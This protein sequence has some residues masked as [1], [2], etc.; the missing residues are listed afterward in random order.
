ML[1]TIGFETMACLRCLVP[2]TLAQ[3][4]ISSLAACWRC[5]QQFIPHTSPA[6]RAAASRL[7]SGFCPYPHPHSGVSPARQWFRQ[8]NR[9]HARYHRITCSPIWQQYYLWSHL[10][11][12]NETQQHY[13]QGQGCLIVLTNSST[14]LQAQS[15]ILQHTII[16]DASTIPLIIRGS[17]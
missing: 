7:G 4:G 16:L 10:R 3:F 17:V 1:S 13:H 12:W 11:V 14:E 15:P 5:P 6:C 8:P 9:S 2:T